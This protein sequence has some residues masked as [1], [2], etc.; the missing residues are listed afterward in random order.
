MQIP[1]AT[2]RLQ[3][4]KGFRLPD[5]LALVPYLHDLGISHLYA[6]PLFKAT[7]NSLHGYDVTDYNQLNPELGTEADL[8]KLAH[9]LHA[10][11]MGL[12]LDIVPNH[13]GIATPENGWWWDVLMNGQRSRFAGHFDIDWKPLDKEL[14]GKI[15]VPVLGA[16]YETVLDRGELQ[17]MFEHGRIILG[18]HEHRFPIAPKT[19]SKLPAGPDALKAVNTDHRALDELIRLQPY[20]LMHYERGDRQLNYRRF[21]AISTLAAVCVEEERIFA[22]THALL[23]RWLERGWL[24]GLRVDH[25][26]GLRDPL[27]YLERL[28]RLAPEAWIV[29]EKILEPG[30]SMPDAW[31][32]QGTTGYDFLIRLNENFIDPEA[33][34]ALNA[35]Y[36]S[37][38][39]EASDYAK[40]LFEKKREVIAN[41]FGAEMN[42]VVGLL[43][44]IAA[45]RAVSQNYER[46]QL[47]EAVAAIIA[48]FPVYRTYLKP[49]QAPSA[50]DM[51]AVKRAVHLACEDRPDLPAEL[52][53]F[54]D[55]LLL[56]PQRGTAARNFTA[57]FQQLTSA[58]MAKGAEDTAFY[59]FNR[60][61]SQNEVGGEPL[62]LGAQPAALHQ[63]LQ[64]QQMAWP[65]TQLATSTHDTKRA[66]DVR[67][68]INVISEAPELWSPAVQRWAQM[69]ACHRENNLPDRNTEYLF[70]QTLTGAWPLTEDRAQHYMEK[71][72][73]EA[74]VHTTWKQRNE[75]YE[76]AVRKFVSETLR[77]PEFTTDLEHW[78]GRLADAAAVNTVAQTLIKLT[79][80]GVPDIYQGCELPDYS[81]VDPDNRRPVDFNVRRTS[82]ETAAGLTADQAWERRQTGLAKL[83][84]IQRALKLRARIPGWHHFGYEP[85]LATGEKAA[86]VFAF[87]RG[88]QILTAVPRLW[89]KL[90]GDWQDTSLDLPEGIWVSEFTGQSFQGKVPAGELL[91]S[92][93][94]ALLVRKEN[95]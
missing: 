84:I 42:R 24:D 85:I 33:E 54:I 38:T 23:G 5:A 46:A 21:F 14:H 58:V 65:H 34:P 47:H 59:S 55:A 56:K 49:G 37:F 26:D 15:A 12:V 81:L 7:A 62:K 75:A 20:R 89:L 19:A 11:K 70:Y 10:K 22:A 30:E 74:G 77:D 25:P 63:F 66:E 88:G 93:P 6:S 67:A 51:A 90:N 52:F 40:L 87:I 79:A 9:A 2:Y 32:V 28:R 27:E 39:G 53:A 50:A 60:F 3:F 69:N 73:R 41:L 57:R 71:A 1:R 31:P 13:M 64:H 29:V 80:P 45:L 82:L 18:Y 61:V 76:K 94:A 86:H 72:V 95:A 92:L 36:E 91:K 17:L 83:W 44:R 48:R 8:E 68:R 43:A 78:V 4:H 16:E 35:F